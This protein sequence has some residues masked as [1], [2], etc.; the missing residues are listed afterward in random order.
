[1]DDC[2]ENKAGIDINNDSLQIVTD[3]EVEGPVFHSV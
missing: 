2:P 3:S 1:M